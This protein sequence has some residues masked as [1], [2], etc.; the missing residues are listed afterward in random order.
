NFSSVDGQVSVKLETSLASPIQD[1]LDYLTH[2]PHFCVEQTVSRF[3]PNL[4]TRQ[5]LMNFSDVVDSGE[6]DTQLDENLEAALTKLIEEQD[7]DGGW[8]WFGNMESHPY[9][10]AYV[11]LALT[12]AT[13]IGIEIPSQI[14]DDASNFL[15]NYVSNFEIDITSEDFE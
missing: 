6:L 11:L 14:L 4:I 9:V 10:S 7:A 12:D 2:F 8:G 5:T 1:G 15:T 3:Y 13:K